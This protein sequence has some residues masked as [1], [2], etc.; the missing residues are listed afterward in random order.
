[1]LG[2]L[3]GA[4]PADQESQS[5]AEAVRGDIERQLARNF[6]SFQVHSYLTQ[7]VAGLNYKLKVKVGHDEYLHCKVYKPL[8]HTG[9]AAELKECEAGKAEGDPFSN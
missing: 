6:E 3:S 4:K 5:I 1:M 7:V 2:G 8:P 9:G